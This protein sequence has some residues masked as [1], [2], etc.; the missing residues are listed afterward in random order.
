MTQRDDAAGW[1][2]VMTQP[3]AGLTQPLL[4]G[5]PGPLAGQR[6]LSWTRKP[7]LPQEPLASGSQRINQGEP[8]LGTP[9]T[10]ADFSPPAATYWPDPLIHLHSFIHS[11]VPSLLPLFHEG[12]L[13]RGHA[14]RGWGVTAEHTRHAASLAGKAP[15]AVWDLPRQALSGRAQDLTQRPPAKT[16]LALLSCSRRRGKPISA[17]RAN[18]PSRGCKWVPGRPDPADRGALQ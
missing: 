14:A 7:R 8:F 16:G 18:L 9:V 2:R 6:L 13:T 5:G 4:Q 17:T 15:A 10:L 1:R 3:A 11:F 12:F